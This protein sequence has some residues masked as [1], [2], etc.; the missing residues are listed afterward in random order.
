[1]RIV[2]NIEPEGYSLK[3][4]KIWQKNG[5]HY[6]EGSWSDLESNSR[7][8]ADVEVLIVRLK[9]KI[10][11]SVI[12]RFPNLKVLVSAT[13]GHD[14]IDVEMLKSKGIKLSSLR[15]HDGFL[16]T[17]PSTAEHTWS[18]LM[19]LI[20]KIPASV[21][22]VMEGGWERDLFRGIQL[23]NKTLG[24]VGYGRTGKMVAKYAK[25][26][27]MNVLY[28]DPFVN[29]ESQFK[30]NDISVL[31][32]Y[33]DILSFHLHLNDSTVN[34]LNRTNIH[35]VKK[36]AFIINTSRGAILDEEV[37]VE[38]LER[39][40]IGGIATDVLCNELDNISKSALWKAFKKNIYNILITPHIG[41]ATWDAMWACEEFLAKMVS[42]G[43]FT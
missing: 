37:V 42:S 43:Q 9:K 17:I 1:M 2:Y 11:K 32:R 24:I 31:F 21:G 6:I 8:F 16:K 38:A 23:K 13:T 25:A 20:R 35:L 39:G 30:V 34:F 12:S 33:S 40:Q 4:K 5:F 22:H 18:L 36:G 3:A 29:S 7:L 28:Y 10:S 15:G 27:E 41:G 26:F 19:A 14:H